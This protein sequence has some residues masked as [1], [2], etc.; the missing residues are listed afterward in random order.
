MIVLFTDFGLEGPYIG[1]L[2]A[3]LYRE[4]PGVQVINLQADAPA[5]DP[6]SSAYL[7]ASYA[8][9]FLSESVFLCVV[10]PGVG[11]AR[12]PLAVRVDG[13]WFIAPDN[14]LLE[15][16]MRRATVVEPFVITWQPPC[17]G[18]S[19]HGRDLFAPVA[20]RLARGYSVPI[21][22]I[23]KMDVVHNDCP[24]DLPAVVYIDRFGNGITGLRANAVKTETV[25]SCGAYHLRWARTFSEVPIGSSFW[26]EN[27]NGLVEIAVNQGRA[28][29]RLRLKV[30]TRVVIN[31]L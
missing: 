5:G 1:Q 18:A 8:I 15:L 10:D 6:L 16:V 29:D 17:L 13:V 4:A 11:S 3:V 24:D 7:L 30:G 2:L 9:G 31:P 12:L 19:F 26:Y 23:S 22:E 21:K 14:G 27:A 20:A 25:L 28:V